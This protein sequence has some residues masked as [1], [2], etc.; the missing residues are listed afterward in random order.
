MLKTK[1][2]SVQKRGKRLQK[3]TQETGKWRVEIEKRRMGIGRQGSSGKGM[4]DGEDGPIR[5]DHALFY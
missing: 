1:K 2:T 3:T 4:L 5:D